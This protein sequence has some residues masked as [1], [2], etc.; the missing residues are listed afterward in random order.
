[1]V[2]DELHFADRLCQ[3]IRTKKSVLCCGLDPQLKFMPMHLIRAAIDRHGETNKA[4][5]WLFFEFNRLIIDAVSDLVVCVKP[6]FAF[7]QAYGMHGVGAYELTL[8][9]AKSRGLL[10][11]GDAKP[12]DGGDTAD[13]YADGHIGQIPFF[14]GVVMD[15]PIQADCVTV[16][17]YIGT[18]C[19]GKFVERVKKFGKGIFVVTKTSFKPNSEVEQIPVDTVANRG[20][21][22][23]KVV[24]DFVKEW[25]DKTRNG[26]EMNNVG[27]VMGATYPDEAALMRDYLP[28][29]FFLIPGYGSQGGGAKDAVVGIRKDGLGGIVNSSRALTY[30]WCDEKGQ[31]KCEPRL[32]ADAARRRAVLDRDVLVDALRQTNRWP[33]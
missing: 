32:F 26:C 31:F 8:Q 4:M 7:Y 33:F 22:V 15:S 28:D 25:G 30:A 18:A 27:V 5:G 29:S 17:P 23:W 19:V 11:I 16:N 10:S 21:R 12:G 20:D 6:N 3:A 13:A 9:Y 24:A 2:P 14:G 1:M